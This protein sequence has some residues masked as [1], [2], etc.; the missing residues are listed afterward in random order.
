[1]VAIELKPKNDGEALKVAKVVLKRRDRNLAANAERAKTIQNLRKLR[2]S[3]PKLI[4]A[5]NGDQLLRRSVRRNADK[6]NIIISKKK[7]L[8]ERRI[9]EDAKSLLVA[10]NERVP[11]SGK[12]RSA[13]S[14]L[15]VFGPNDCR[16]V[17]TTKKNLDLL[18]ACDAYVY[19]G[20]PTPETISTLVHKKA[21]IAASKDS[22]SEEG[23]PKTPTPLNNNAIV[24]DV[25]GEH[26]LVCVEDLVDILIRGRENEELF[27]KV[28]QFISS[29]K[30]NR[31]SRMPGSK[32]RNDRATRG[33]Q[34]KIET[35]MARLI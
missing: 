19:Y 1:M 24:E 26:G 28:S 2:K 8:L 13:L 15:G 7:Q 22:T 10:R 5:V 34:P 3:K 18:R 14:K 33:F 35:I 4:A 16:I 21:Y 11:N 29:F 6:D 27:G 30:I 23:T 31:E 12:A 20:V 9:P 32:F 17:T 25:F